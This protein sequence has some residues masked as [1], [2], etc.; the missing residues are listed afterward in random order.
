MLPSL[1]TAH[2]EWN[3]LK[4]QDHLISQLSQEKMEKGFYPECRGAL[5]ELGG[6]GK[7]DA[8]L[9]DFRYIL[10]VYSTRFPDEFDV[11]YEREVLKM[12]ISF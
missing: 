8:K 7:G 2:S 5:K 11:G 4:E 1:K 9:S 12:A 10:Q 6:S 3:S